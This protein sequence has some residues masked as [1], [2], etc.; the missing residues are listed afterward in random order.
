MKST[1]P[2]RTTR[3]LIAQHPGSLPGSA[4][5]AGAKRPAVAY[6]VAALVVAMTIGLTVT[7]VEAASS[8]IAQ[9]PLIGQ[10]APE[11][12]LM[13]M[14]DDSGSMDRDWLPSPP[15][16]R[17]SNFL[18]SF[19]S[20]HRVNVLDMDGNA[21][22]AMTP[23]EVARL[24]PGVNGLAYDPGITYRPW[25]DDNKPAANNFPNQPIGQYSGSGA[26][27]NGPRTDMRTVMLGGVRTPVDTSRFT[28]DFFRRPTGTIDGGVCSKRS[29]GFNKVCADNDPTDDTDEEVCT[30]T[31]GSYCSSWPKVSKPIPASSFRI[32]GGWAN[33]HDVTRY[34]IVE[35]DRDKP[36]RMYEVPPDPRTGAARQRTDCAALTTCTFDEEARNYANWSTYY[37]TRML[38]SLGVTSETLSTINTPIRL[39]YGRLGYYPDAYP[40]WPSHPSTYPPST[41]PA[42][43]GQASPHHVQRGVR[44]FDPGSTERSAVFDWLFQLSSV[45]NTHNREALNSAGEYFSRSDAR[46]PWA[47]NPGVSGGGK[48]DLAC[49]RSYTLLVTDG[50]WN[51]ISPPRRFG[52]YTTAWGNAPHSADSTNGPTITGDGSQSGRSYSYRPNVEKAISGTLGS[53]NNTFAD[54]AFFYW[55]R[56]LRPDLPNIRTP[57]RWPGASGETYPADYFDP[58]TWQ[59]MTTMVIA[60]GLPEFITE[61]LFQDRLRNGGGVAWPTVNFEEL[62]STKIADTQRGALASRGKYYS[63]N[64]AQE[65][66][67]ALNKVLQSLG[68]RKASGTSVAVS[69]PIIDGG[70][71]LAFQASYNLEDW[72][73]GLE[74]ISATSLM[75]TASV[76]KWEASFPADWRLRKIYTTH[77]TNSG[78]SFDWT[79]LSSAQRTAL[80]SEAIVNY[81]RGDRSAEQPAG[82]LR[83]RAT[84]LG[85]IV[86]SSPVYSR[87]TNFGYQRLPS[88]GGDNYLAYLASKEAGRL[89]SVMVGSNDGML[90]SFDARTG[91]ELF[92]FVPRAVIPHLSNYTSST[93]EQRFLV[94]GP[95]SE[96]DAYIGGSWKTVAVGTS[97]AGP[98]SLFAL[99]I[100]DP[101]SFGAGKVL[102]DLDANDLP[103]LGHVMGRPIIASTVAG[104]WV[105]IVANG[106]ES[107]DHR[108]V[109]LVIDLATGA[110]LR[111]IDTGVGQNVAG[112][113]NGLGAVT[114]I[115]NGRRDVIGIYAGD[116]LGNVWKFDLS[117]ESAADWKVAGSS[118]G[119]ATPF[120]VATDATNVRQPITSEIRV[121][122]HPLGGRYLVFGTGKY[123]ETGDA[124]STSTQAIYA[125]RDLGDIHSVAKNQ[126]QAGTLSNLGAG[127]FRSVSGLYP[128]DW[129]AKRGWY[130]P[131]VVGAGGGGERVIAPPIISGSQVTFT[132]FRPVE[133]DACTS[134]GTSYLYVLDVATGL[135]SSVYHDQAANVIG[136]K[137]SDG[138][139]GGMI[140]LYAPPAT[141]GVTVTS[142]DTSEV[143]GL[144]NDTLYTATSTGFQS[145]SS[146]SRCVAVGTSMR[147]IPLTAP[148]QCAGT[149]PLRVWRDLR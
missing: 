131:L 62:D 132:S 134:A 86:K 4:K 121:T 48:N 28:Y 47:D 126:L 27:S 49:R 84:V 144:I 36:G 23:K 147:Q 120:F 116:K 112:Q 130:L 110:I 64:N 146:G 128:I 12:N 96:G 69:A 63:A 117:S 99:D 45:V 14:F 10:F 6:A 56:D 35:I 9:K 58:A 17:W 51:D 105:A 30:T 74:A 149:L 100:T 95:I 127:E 109:L 141:G 8:D 11:P 31:W 1:K 91:A 80:G 139:P 94:D 135:S 98:R 55:S 108:A 113:R 22:T 70:E 57:Q 21:V 72:D 73:G 18:S 40:Q 54:A 93:A 129:S 85:A 143:G 15:D 61:E 20:D 44:R 124:A 118:G 13:L 2:R 77:A 53:Q 16:F 122:E 52:H 5:V 41:L 78:I 75:D 103:E 26:F 133:V 7:R 106:Y 25:N 140:P 87:A 101:S 66:A 33:R 19:S 145:R 46:G 32:V 34:R 29:S 67:Q 90:H 115:Y 123:F 97:G 81:L 3:P 24:T 114:P 83:R 43:D 142:L 38:A 148:V 65:L 125:I 37:R 137:L 138:V 82:S 102:F 89:A 50:G 68:S 119:V 79:S 60:Y 76:S 104:K 107:A 111:K 136:Q 59:N 39:G 88:A 42:L 92:A 71:T